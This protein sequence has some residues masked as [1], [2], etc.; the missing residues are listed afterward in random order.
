MPTVVIEGPQLSMLRKRRLMVSITRAVAQAYD[1]PEDQII[2]I[3][4]A[5]PDQ[6]IARGGRLLSDRREREVR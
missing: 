4:H 6:N 2:I 5:N 3:L 1:W